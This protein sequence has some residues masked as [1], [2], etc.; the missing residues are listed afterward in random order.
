MK[1]RFLGSGR[2]EASDLT[3][4]CSGILKRVESAVL[5][6]GSGISD[7]ETRGV[8]TAR[9]GNLLML[10]SRWAWSTMRTESSGESGAAGAGFLKRMGTEY[11]HRTFTPLSLLS[12]PA[13]H[14]LD[15]LKRGGI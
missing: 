10:S 15:N 13:R 14:G 1:L 9:G 12:Y 8:R 7:F 2:T 5:S 6:S 11:L 3:R 4:Y